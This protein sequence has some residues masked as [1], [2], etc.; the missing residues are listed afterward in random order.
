MWHLVQSYD[1]YILIETDSNNT[2]LGWILTTHKTHKSPWNKSIMNLCG[3]YRKETSPENLY[4]WANEYGYTVL[5][6]FD[7]SKEPLKY[8]IKHHPEFLI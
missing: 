4:E 6:S 2:T 5:L 3:E 8:I 7:T 1:E